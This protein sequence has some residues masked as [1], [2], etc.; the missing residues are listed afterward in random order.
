MQRAAEEKVSKATAVG[1][2]S[3][4]TSDVSRDGTWMTKRHSSTVGVTTAIG[5]NTGKAL[6]TECKSNVCKSC[7]YWQTE[8]PSTERFRKQDEEHPAECTVTHYGSSGSMATAAETG[9]FCRSET[10]H[11]LRYIRFIGDMDTNSCLFLFFKYI[12]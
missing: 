12:S 2:D 3:S 9:I 8:D 5:R 4:R 1:G 6:D 7:E 10:P 11:N